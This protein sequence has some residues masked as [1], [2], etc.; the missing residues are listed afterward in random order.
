VC[1]AAPTEEW[2]ALPK[3]AG[4]SRGWQGPRPHAAPARRDRPPRPY[5][6]ATRIGLR[7]GRA[8]RSRAAAVRGSRPRHDAA[9]DSLYRCD[10][11]L[12]WIFLPAGETLSRFYSPGLFLQPG[13]GR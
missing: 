3:A 12:R 4:R 2:A 8:P 9:R 13:P 6:A 10:S 5:L 11:L 1:T 7:C